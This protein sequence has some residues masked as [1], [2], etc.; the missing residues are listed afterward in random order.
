MDLWTRSTGKNAGFK[1]QSHYSKGIKPLHKSCLQIYPISSYLNY[2]PMPAT[3]SRRLPALMAIAIG[4]AL[5]IAFK[6]SVVDYSC[7]LF[8]TLSDPGTG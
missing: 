6:W 4:A 7:L 2:L 5:R 8:A 3:I 1:H